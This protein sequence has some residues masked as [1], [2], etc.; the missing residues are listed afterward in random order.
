MDHHRANAL[1]LKQMGRKMYRSLAFAIA[2]G[3]GFT[4]SAASAAKSGGCDHACL[5][6][7]LQS[8]ERQVLRHHTEGIA[9]TPD[10]RST[11][12]Y[13]PV[14]LG[15]GYWRRIGSIYDQIIVADAEKEQV[16]A[17]GS[18]DDA[19]RRAY[20][21][22]RLKLEPGR[23]ISQSE[24]MIV[25]DGETSFLQK[26]PAAKISRVYVEPVPTRQ[27]SSRAGLLKLSEGFTDAWQFKDEDLARFAPSCTFSEN[28]VMLSEPGV[29]T[30]G[31]MLEY[32]GKRGIPGNGVGPNRGNPN[33][34]PRP[35]RP[36]DPSIGRPEL[37]GSMPWMRDR[38]YPIVDT[39]TG[40]VLSYHIQGGEPARP[41]E[42]VQYRRATPFAA[43]SA[44]ARRTATQ[45]S[46]TKPRP[47][48]PGSGAA[49]MAGLI[50]V[51]NGEIIKVDH[52]EWEGGPNASGGFADGPP[53]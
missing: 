36:A 34:Q 13:E 25:R 26:D 2:I 16:A 30:C 48:I 4:A 6:R 45:N 35:T 33:T 12:N 43:S 22:L 44:G 23:R 20:F 3:A 37:Q 42:A 29:T 52:F 41:G 53:N 15:E 18:L 38:R 10:F 21:V 7:A 47:P 5:T 11:E 40:I 8:Y 24:M 1:Q 39:E 31:D 49:Y 17:V 28:N 51:V 19:G 27:R 32:M 14:A 46:S 9:L 50:K